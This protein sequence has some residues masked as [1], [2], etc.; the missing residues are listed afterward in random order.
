MDEIETA[1]ALAIR[2]T[3]QKMLADLC[4]QVQA[5]PTRYGADPEV[6]YVRVRDVLALLDGGE[7]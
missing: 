3:R 5:L 4:E 1:V 6:L 2:L 7:Q